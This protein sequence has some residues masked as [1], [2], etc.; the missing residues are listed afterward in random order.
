[1][2]GAGSLPL[3]G[4][5]ACDRMSEALG[6]LRS[7][8]GLVARLAGAEAVSLYLPPGAAGERE[9]LVQAGAGP[10]LPEL[11]DPDAAAAFSARVSG[12]PGPQQDLTRLAS[13]YEGGVLYR[14]PLHWLVPRD[15]TPGVER[16]K[17]AR[18]R[19]G[20][21]EVWLGLR[22]ATRSRADAL[23][24][25]P[26]A[27]EALRNDD[28]WDAFLGLGAAFALHT[29]A[30]SRRLQ[31]Q[32]TGLPERREFQAELEAAIAQRRGRRRCC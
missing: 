9:V 4:R 19:S 30:I 8:A 20:E 13:E 25:A 23:E 22:F 5:T 7:Y 28:W 18:R 1:M 16:R 14:I 27:A 15:D 31:D 26:S 10:P 6:I 24:P 2:P 21:P 3:P 29:R 32:V 11:A 17:A 12:L